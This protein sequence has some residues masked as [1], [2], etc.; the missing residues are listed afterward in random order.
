LIR[1][2]DLQDLELGMVSFLQS[3]AASLVAQLTSV[4]VMLNFLIS[5][6]SIFN[7]SN[8]IR[9]TGFNKKICFKINLQSSLIG[10]FERRKSRLAR[11]ARKVSSDGQAC[12][13]GLRPQLKLTRNHSK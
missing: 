3:R 6:I 12:F 1:G 9:A 11:Y 13:H 10:R 2:S 5:E 8:E 4:V 7:L